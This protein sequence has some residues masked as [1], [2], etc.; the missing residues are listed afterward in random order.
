MGWEITRG[1]DNNS[2]AVNES[3]YRELKILHTATPLRVLLT[4]TRACRYSD[5]YCCY[6]C[7]RRSPGRVSEFVDLMQANTKICKWFCFCLVGTFRV[8][9]TVSVAWHL[10]NPLRYNFMSFW[11]QFICQSI[12]LRIK[13]DGIQMGS[14]LWRWEPTMYNCLIEVMEGEKQIKL[15]LF[16]QIHAFTNKQTKSSF[17]CVHV[18]VRTKSMISAS[19][20][21]THPSSAWLLNPDASSQLWVAKAISL[22]LNTASLCIGWQE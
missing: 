20:G 12:S 21:S 7:W 13:G 1:A 18:T 15:M 2:H 19:F 11:K 8:S 5:N 6:C 3:N 9:G 22:I 10:P 14:E 16:V 4:Q 17:F